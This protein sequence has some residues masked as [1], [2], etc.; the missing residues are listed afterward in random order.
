MDAP[1]L[2]EGA[3]KVAKAAGGLSEGAIIGISICVSFFI[4]FYIP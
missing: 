2:L 3:A 1:A 4:R